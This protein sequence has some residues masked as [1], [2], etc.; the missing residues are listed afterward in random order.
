MFEFSG[1]SM[2]Q[3][4]NDTISNFDFAVRG[5]TDLE[6][7]RNRLIELEKNR[8]FSDED[9]AMLL[10]KSVHTNLKAGIE[11]RVLNRRS[12]ASNERTASGRAVIR[13]WAPALL[14][15]A[16]DESLNENDD[17]GWKQFSPVKAVGRAAIATPPR[18]EPAFIGKNLK[19]P[20]RLKRMQ[21]RNFIVT[22]L[23]NI[24]FIPKQA[25]CSLV[26]LVVPTSDRRAC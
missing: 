7:A 2:M 18:V 15:E 10:R 25:V 9:L 16:D 21:S 11:S 17:D 22:F 19:R 8:I 5:Y 14:E 24:I 26:S 13:S 6:T 4:A 12:R 20:S 1:E 23:A 3:S